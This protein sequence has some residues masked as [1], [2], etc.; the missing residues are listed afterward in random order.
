MSCYNT[1][2]I[3]T[4]TSTYNIFYKQDIIMIKPQKCAKL[5]KKTQI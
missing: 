2:D 1:F 4:P 3:S 5:T